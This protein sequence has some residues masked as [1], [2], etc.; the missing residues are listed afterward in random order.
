MDIKLV[1][2]GGKHAGRKIPVT[3]EKFFIGRAED[4]HLRPNSDLVSRHHCAITVEPDEVTIRDFGSRN[5]TLVNGDRIR[6]EV[7]L[8]SGDHLQIGPLEFEVL[9]EV[10]LAGHKKPKVKS[11]EEAAARTVESAAGTPADN[12]LDISDWLADTVDSSSNTKTMDTVQ[13]GTAS[14][15][16]TAVTK[17]ETTSNEP[18]DK[19]EAE[20]KPK[21]PQPKSPSG[22]HG[23]K[24]PKA[25]DS[26]SAAADTLRA[27]FNRK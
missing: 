8:H 24:K 20:Q 10:S 18:E 15:D 6:G 23:L 17:E 2:I 1:V 26:Q 21:K 12:D 19:Q 27:F 16:T 11:V 14:M 13:T 4:C 3:G 9:L 25:I 7:D 5:G 22:I